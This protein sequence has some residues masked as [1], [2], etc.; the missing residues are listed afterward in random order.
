MDGGGRVGCRGGDGGGHGGG[1][2]LPFTSLI[3][4]CDSNRSYIDPY[5]GGSSSMGD[6]GS[7]G[8]MSGEGTTGGEADEIAFV[9]YDGGQIAVGG[10]RVGA[11]RCG[12]L[13][14]V[15]SVSAAVNGTNNG[16]E[17]NVEVG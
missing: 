3:A 12:W 10:E 13:V 6:H 8:G 15:R 14:V 4:A 5:I 11:R 9:G 17:S 16:G 2:S 1:A 7:T